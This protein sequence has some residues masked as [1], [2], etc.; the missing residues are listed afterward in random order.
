MFYVGVYVHYEGS[1][2]AKEARVKVVE[3]LGHSRGRAE[4]F[5]NSHPVVEVDGFKYRALVMVM[6][7]RFRL[8]ND[9]IKLSMRAYECDWQNAKFHCYRMSA[10]DVI[11]NKDVWPDIFPQKKKEEK[12][13]QPLIIAPTAQDIAHVAK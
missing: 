8:S 10:Q 5:L 9:V 13:E 4:R 1:E 6:P 7:D 3:K 2:K 11:G 12:K